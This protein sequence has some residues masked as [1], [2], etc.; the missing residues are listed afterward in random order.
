MR[1]KTTKR[2]DN[3]MVKHF[4]LNRFVLTVSNPSFV[5]ET[6][7]I[8]EGG[9]GGLDGANG[10]CGGHPWYIVATERNL[11]VTQFGIYFK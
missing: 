7:V 4:N 8:V 3:F 1:T 10:V 9:G 11:C 2:D 5:R 6:G